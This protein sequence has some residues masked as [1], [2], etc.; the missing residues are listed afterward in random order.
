MNKRK[1]RDLGPPTSGC[2]ARPTGWIDAI[3]ICRKC[4]KKLD[5]GFGVD[6]TDSLRKALRTVLRASGERQ[7]IGLIDISCL[8]LC[9][10]GAVTV[11]R[12]SQPGEMRI[13]PAGADA[14]ALLTLPG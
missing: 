11:L 14:A 9:P 2:L 4:G 1:R 6:G 3:L 7:R 5:G 8:G 13:V 10:K 12:A